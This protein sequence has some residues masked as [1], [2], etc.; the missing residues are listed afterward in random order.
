MSQ[1][2]TEKKHSFTMCKEMKHNVMGGL[3]DLFLLF[4]LK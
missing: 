4:V 2:V 1:T 3:N